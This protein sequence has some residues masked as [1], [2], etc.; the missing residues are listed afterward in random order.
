MKSFNSRENGVH[1]GGEGVAELNLV[2]H[3]LKCMIIKSVCNKINY[4][5]LEKLK[6][7]Q[8]PHVEL[9]RSDDLK[10]RDVDHGIKNPWRWE[11]LDSAVTVDVKKTLSEKTSW[12][13]GPLKMYPKDYI[14]KV[15]T[16]FLR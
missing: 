4:L 7:K 11:W 12:T 9:T 6:S 10:V 5:V 13:G 15:Y 8:M 1:R 16:S 3:P 14:R 2:V